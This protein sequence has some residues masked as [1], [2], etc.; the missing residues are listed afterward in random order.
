M[1]N[2][3]IINS[4]SRDVTEGAMPPEALPS[5]SLTTG[6]QVLEA[7]RDGRMPGS[8]ISHTMPMQL[9]HVGSGEVAM[10]AMPDTRHMNPSGMVHGG[11]AATCIDSAAALALFS[12]LDATT[13][14]ST[15]DL[16]ITYVRPLAQNTQYVVT[17]RLKERT[18]SLGLCSAEIRD[19]NDKLYA[20][21]SATLMIKAN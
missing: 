11:F 8:S 21:G 6:L 2:V 12:S 16:N 19:V 15:V 4:S 18:K 20:L 9:T 1:R 17:G 14:Y 5:P 13:P 7:I 10:M 3:D